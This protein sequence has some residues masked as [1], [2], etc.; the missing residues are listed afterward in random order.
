MKTNKQTKKNKF[1]LK[2]AREKRNKK[3]QKDK[4]AIMDLSTAKFIMDYLYFKRE[5]DTAY[6]YQRKVSFN[7][8]K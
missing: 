5:N 2:K 1:F 3:S 7:V 6:E 4:K 8:H